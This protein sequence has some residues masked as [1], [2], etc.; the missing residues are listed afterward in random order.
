MAEPVPKVGE[1]WRDKATGELVEI[2]GFG[3]SR[4]WIRG[5]AGSRD[6]RY[7]Y[8]RTFLSRFTRVEPTEGA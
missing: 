2:D 6:R 5:D 3:G 4:I 1:V 8:S 7:H